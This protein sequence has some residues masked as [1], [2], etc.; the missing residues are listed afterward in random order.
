MTYTLTSVLF[1]GRKGVWGGRGGGLL[2]SWSNH[3]FCTKT[4]KKK[5]LQ[6]FPARLTSW[7]WCDIWTCMLDWLA[8]CTYKDKNISSPF[9]FLFIRW[10]PQFLNWRWPWTQDLQTAVELANL[11]DLVRAWR[12]GRTAADVLLSDC[13]LCRDAALLTRIRFSLLP[14]V[15]TGLMK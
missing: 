9:F 14:I 6:G 4:N 5:F 8:T 2:F 12:V 7:L 3:Y 15:E 10:E 13:Q 11:W 1:A